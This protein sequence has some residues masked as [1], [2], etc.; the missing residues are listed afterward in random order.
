MARLTPTRQ[1]RGGRRFAGQTEH[2]TPEKVICPACKSSMSFFRG[3]NALIGECGFE[4]YRLSC[5]GCGTDISV[6]VDPYDDALLI[7]QV[8]D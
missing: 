5:D 7:S 4:S 3:V 1:I 8:Q 2:V 6:I